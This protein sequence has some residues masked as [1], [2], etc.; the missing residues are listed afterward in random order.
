MAAG[1][2]SGGTHRV[3]NGTATPP[4]FH[5]LNLLL[6]AVLRRLLRRGDELGPDCPRGAGLGGRARHLRI[7]RM[8]PMPDG[9][10]GAAVRL[11]T[12]SYSLMGSPGEGAETSD[13]RVIGEAI[14]AL[15]SLAYQL[16]EKQRERVRHERP[17]DLAERWG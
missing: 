14:P 15:E 17:N 11:L 9:E 4:L 13:A 12:L 5:L 1:T 7:R 8:E 10:L 3:A 2:I 16:L 6:L